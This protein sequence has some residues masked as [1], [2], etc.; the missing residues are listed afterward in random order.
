MYLDDIIIDCKCVLKLD[1][2]YNLIN[3]NKINNFEIKESQILY[4]KI[5]DNLKNK[6]ILYLN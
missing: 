1:E 2:Q 3:I 4:D 6:T 5:I